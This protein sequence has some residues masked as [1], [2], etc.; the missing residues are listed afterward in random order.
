MA[1]NH[2]EITAHYELAKSAAPCHGLKQRYEV[3]P[4]FIKARDLKRPEEG[5]QGGDAAHQ[6]IER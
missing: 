1:F 3:L 2:S 5:D 6:D 4:K